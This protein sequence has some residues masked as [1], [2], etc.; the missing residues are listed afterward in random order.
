MKQFSKIEGYPPE[1]VG[2]LNSFIVTE[3]DDSMTVEMQLRVLIK[4][5]LK[6]IDLTNEMVDYLNKFIEDFDENLH[7][8]VFDIL[9]QWRIDGVLINDI[10][11]TILKGI[12]LQ[13][14][15]VQTMLEDRSLT[16]G[17]RVATGGY[18][19]LGDGGSATYLIT[20]EEIEVDLGNFRLNN[21]LYAKLIHSGIVNIKQFG[22]KGDGIT[23][24]LLS[25]N[26]AIKYKNVEIPNGTYCVSD[27]IRISDGVLFYGAVPTSREIANGAQFKYIGNIDNEKAC[28][29]IGNNEVKAE[30]VNA[31]SSITI[32]N[33]YI[34]CNDRCGFGIYG[35]YL[36]NETSVKNVAV[37]NSLEYN[38]YFAKSW[39][40]TYDNLTSLSC[41]NCGIAIGMPLE[42]LNGVNINW[43]SPNP[44]ECNNV[45][46]SNLR[47][48]LAGRYFE[49]DY[50]YDY[51]IAS[52]R[53]KGFG[54]GIGIG[55]GMHV[56]GFTSER[57]GGVALYNYTASQPVKTIRDGYIEKTCEALPNDDRKKIGIIIENTIATGGTHILD[58]I[59]MSNTNGGGILVTGVSG[60]IVR[61]K[62]I[63]QPKFIVSYEYEGVSNN[64]ELFKTILKENSYSGLGTY[65][66]DVNS[67]KLEFDKYNINSRYE[68]TGDEVIRYKDR[69]SM[70]PFSYVGT[71]R[72]SVRSRTG[73]QPHGSL[74]V[75]D[76][77]GGTQNYN[78]P[79]TLPVNEWV[80]VGLPSSKYIGISKGGLTGD[81]NVLY[82]LKVEFLEPTYY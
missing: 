76:A 47:S 65:N 25:I 82:D 14:P 50:H 59:F 41:R 51:E 17:S 23:D 13:Y 15:N 12:V 6:N 72:I 46:I 20:S 34:D 57:S 61:L 40:C 77:A 66:N 29:L 81:T 78:F 74:A 48:Q 56:N 53:R 31:G 5:I 30:P 39:Y 43:T 32:Q 21:G 58:D 54:I 55:N 24:D 1:L 18:Y 11:N 69:F 4:W 22:A 8:T 37:R 7:Q 36:S 68:F 27:T 71:H 60:R 45:F 38:F 70:I 52:L 44:L 9:E 35:T 63:H 64:Q 2:R 42:F 75:I 79:S 49:K 33:I 16:N 3:F 26:N 80:E 62:N 28:L 10:I 19:Q 67:T 73:E